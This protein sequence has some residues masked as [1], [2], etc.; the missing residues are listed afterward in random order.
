MD[1]AGRIF[2][3]A[4]VIRARRPRFQVTIMWRNILLFQSL[5]VFSLS[6]CATSDPAGARA[7]SEPADLNFRGSDCI[8]IRTIRDYSPLDDQHLLIHGP[9]KRAF[10]VTLFR[11]TFEMRGSFSIQFESRDGQLCPFGGDAVVF[12]G[13]ANERVSIQAISRITPD[14]E[15]QLLIR[16]GKKDAP[17]LETPVKPA[18]VKGAEVEELG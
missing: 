9:S 5:I 16:Y 1:R 8:L 14:Q 7:R 10:F 2:S 3:G 13:F 15:E 18:P 11:P 17:E 4:W 12:G 6:G